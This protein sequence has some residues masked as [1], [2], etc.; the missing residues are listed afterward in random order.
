MLFTEPPVYQTQPQTSNLKSW[1]QVSWSVV[2]PNEI[3]I[4]IRIVPPQQK[5][6]QKSSLSPILNQVLDSAQVRT[7]NRI[8][9]N[10]AKS[11]L[12]QLN[13]RMNRIYD[14]EKVERF[15]KQIRLTR[16]QSIDLEKFRNS[17]LN[18]YKL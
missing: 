15:L 6:H 16:D 10:E 11:I 9:F 7:K 14:D 1:S 17:V 18:S 13:Q 4:P 3:E 5:T 12:A 8:T 2:E